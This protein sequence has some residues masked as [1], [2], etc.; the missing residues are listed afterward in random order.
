MRGCVSSG[1]QMLRWGRSTGVLDHAGL[2]T[3]FHRARPPDYPAGPLRNAGLHWSAHEAIL[4]DRSVF[5]L[6]HNDGQPRPPEQQ[7]RPALGSQVVDQREDHDARAGCPG[8]RL[9]RNLFFIFK[10][11]PVCTL[12]RRLLYIRRRRHPAGCSA[13]TRSRR[14]RVRSGSQCPSRKLLHQTEA[15]LVRQY[16]LC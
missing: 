1:W 10:P 7:Q 6:R 2:R 12:R 16:S 13:H 5:P 11:F 4:S 14:T 15:E 8:G 3:A 9:L